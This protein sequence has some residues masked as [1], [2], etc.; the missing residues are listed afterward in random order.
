MPNPLVSVIIPIHNHAAFAIETVASVLAQTYANLQVIIVDDGST[1]DGSLRV[2]QH[3]G[4]RVHLIRQPNNGPSAA[5]NAGLAVARG[6]YIALLGGDDVCEQERIAHQVSILQSTVHDIIFAPPTMIDADGA[7]L[8]DADFPALYQKVEVNGPLL[9][10]KL[11]IEGNFLCAPS[12]MM[13]RSVL[14]TIGN[15]HNGLIALQ[16]YEYWLRAASRGLS[17]ASFNHRVVRY[18]RHGGGLSTSLPGQVTQTECAYIMNRTLDNAMPSIVRA[19]FPHVLPPTLNVDARLTLFEKA[20]LLLSHPVHDVKQ[21]GVR[22][23]IDLLEAPEERKT[24]VG[25]NV[26]LFRML[27]NATSGH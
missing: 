1:D 17:L 21:A 20:L 26:N 25:Q 16:D 12:A 24:I 27:F 8:P 15:F 2:S 22:C 13:R 11:F 9:F 5:V 4:D 14:N 19:A 18:R 7:V 10:R 3:F 6:D 23:A